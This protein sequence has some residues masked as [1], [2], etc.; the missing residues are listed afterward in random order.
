MATLQDFF[1]RRN[2]GENEEVDE[3]AKSNKDEKKVEEKDDS[4]KSGKIIVVHSLSSCLF[5]C[6]LE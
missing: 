6:N 2:E 1:A 5:I 4:K 3:K